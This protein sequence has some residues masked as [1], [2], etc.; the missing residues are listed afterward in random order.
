V[1]VKSEDPRRPAAETVPVLKLNLI[2]DF[3]TGVYD[4]NLM[5]SAFVA[6][7]AGA[8]HEAGRAVKVSFSAQEWCGHAYAQARLDA[9]GVRLESH[10][11]FD[12]EADETSTLPANAVGLVEDALLVWARG[13]A[14]PVPAPGATVDAPVLRSLEHARLAHVPVAWDRATL[15]RSASS[16]LVTVPAGTFDVDEWT[17]SIAS[18]TGPRSY[19]PGRSPAAPTPRTW[20]FLVER[21]WPHRVIRWT[22]G[23]GARADLVASS[24][25]AYWTM[26]GPGLESALDGL[27]LRPRGPRT[28]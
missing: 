18:A 5:T 28:P 13:L 6:L 1:G 26:N 20:R 23:D 22:R 19:P 17:V 9:S 15:G 12:G 24:R 2:Q 7:T 4:Y 10:S 21:A 27:G 25:I 14:S 8:G 16:S 11:Y 3:S